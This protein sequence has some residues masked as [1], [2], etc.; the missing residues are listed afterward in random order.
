MNQPFEFKN[1]LEGAPRR[2]SDQDG[3]N[4]FAD[5]NPATGKVSDNLYATANDE[6]ADEKPEYVTTHT[7]VGGQLLRLSSLNAGLGL[8]A[9]IATPLWE[10]Q[11]ILLVIACG[12]VSGAMAIKAGNDLRAMKSAAMDRAALG[13][14]KAALVLALL[15]LVC[16]SAMTIFQIAT[17]L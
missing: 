8:A 12:F 13:K 2:I 5:D 3:P 11:L 14:T 1:P 7:G 9:C 17:A 10:A 15:T 16:C 6:P 4:P